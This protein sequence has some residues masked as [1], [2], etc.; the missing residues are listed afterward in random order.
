MPQLDLFE[1]SFLSF[2][3][4]FLVYAF[5]F[6][7]PEDDSDEDIEI[8][9]SY[10]GLRA[11]Q[12]FELLR[13]CVLF[14]NLSY[15]N[16]SRNLLKKSEVM[17]HFF[18]LLNNNKAAEAATS[19]FEQFMDDDLIFLTFSGLAIL[20]SLLFEEDDYSDD[21]F[22]TIIDDFLEDIF[23]QASTV[24]LGCWHQ[25]FSDLFFITFV[26]ILIANLSGLVPYYLTSTVSIEFVF[27][28]SFTGFFSISLL[29]ILTTK[30][31]FVHL[32]L[33]AG[34]P[35]ILIKFIVL[36]ELAS[37]FVRLCSLT[38]RLLANVLSGHVLLKMMVGFSWALLN[39]TLFLVK[40]AFIFPLI[41]FFILVPLEIFIGFLQ[42]VVFVFLLSIY[43]RQ[44][45]A[46]I[47]YV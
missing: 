1:T 23:D 43:L 47:N 24:V 32:F 16:L 9:L 39:K 41:A 19:P 30:A 7:F 27:F 25:D 40:L 10:L 26:N 13:T 31:R 8:E 34:I 21:D 4:S 38:V 22:F 28:F 33:P 36:V 45:L 44:I 18:V 20:A 17:L 2:F 46:N 6:W 37:Y 3:F 35:G 12:Y 11:V 42:A 5:I 15:Y 29:L 14:Y